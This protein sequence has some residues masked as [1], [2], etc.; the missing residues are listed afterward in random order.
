M[1]QCSYARQ[2]A[3]IGAHKG[4]NLKTRQASKPRARTSLHK[5]GISGQCRALPE[6]LQSLA[7]ATLARDMAALLVSAVGGFLLVKAVDAIQQS[8][9]LEQVIRAFTVLIT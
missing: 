4:P 8:S 3:Y 1:Q 9:L 2:Q 5:A 6:A 7:E